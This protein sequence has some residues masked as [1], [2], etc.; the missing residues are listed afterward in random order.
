MPK[1]CFFEQP[2]EISESDTSLDCNGAVFDG[3]QKHMNGLRIDSKG[4]PLSNIKVENCTFRNFQSSGIRITWSEV[5]ARKGSV[6]KEIYSRSPTK[7][8]I[9]KTN[10]IGNGGVG[11]YIDDYVA[12]VTVQDSV[13]RDSGGVGLYLEHSS[14]DNRVLNNKFIRNGF[15]TKTKSHSREAIAVDS[16]AGNQIVGNLFEQNSAG[17]VFL[18]KNCGEQIQDGKNVIRWQHSENNEIRDNLFNNEKIGVWIASRQS[19]QLGAWNC[20]DPPMDASRVYFEDFANK[21]IVID[22]T[23]CGNEVAIR[24]EGDDNRIVDNRFG[25]GTKVTV[26]VPITKR[27]QLLNRPPKGNVIS[28]GRTAECYER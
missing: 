15:G 5:D 14:R 24:V 28:D 8:L 13:I 2:I 17:G 6:Q 4:R 7:I 1:G 25:S 22:N 20:G 12:N 3:H 26:Q 16:S 27:A 11:V 9:N 10:I 18:Y 21:N 19:R 23:F